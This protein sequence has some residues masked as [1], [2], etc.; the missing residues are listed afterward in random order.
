MQ[1]ELVYRSLSD[2]VTFLSGGTPSKSNNLFWSGDLPWVSSGEMTQPK[3]SDTA[4][5]VTYQAGKAYSKI[6]PT[7]TILV[8]VRGMS[9]ANEFRVSLT[10]RDMAFNQDVKALVPRENIYPLF[11]FYSLYGRRFEIKKLASESAHGTKKLDTKV[12]ESI[13]VLL[14]PLPIQKKI[15]AVLSAYDDLIE[16][17]DRRI[18]L[19]EKMAEE[20]Y[21]E[22][23]VRLRFPGHEQVTFYKGI[24]Q[25]WKIK[26]LEDFCERVTDGTHDTPK[27]TDEGYFL[28]TGKNLKNGIV[29]FEGAYK[30]SK[31]DH[32]NI[33]K[34]SGLN[35]GDIVFSNIGTLGSMVIVT[36]D[37]EYSVKNV[38]IFKPFSEAQSIFIY[39]MLKE[40]YVLENLLLHSSG[41]S[42]QFIS[43]KVARNFKVFDPG[44]ILIDK[45][46]KYALHLY[47]QR[48]S[49][50]RAT[51]NLKQTR[52]RLLTRLISGKLSVEDLDIRFPP[53]MTDLQ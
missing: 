21:R 37:I 8:V 38:L 16:N 7:G 18:A 36:D 2:C 42:Q 10:Q 32:L 40:R 5:H 24:P 44:K 51:S 47:Q 34:R 41:A 45:F 39:Y 3:I 27:P 28:I 6:V 48:V 11:L 12:L 19:L 4:L 17:N 52:D 33:S 31:Q 26:R 20:I 14:P 13:P 1:V 23:F 46:G 35:P 15:A 9:L 53:S 29:D 43:L 30:I 22:W 50:V 25:D 49:L